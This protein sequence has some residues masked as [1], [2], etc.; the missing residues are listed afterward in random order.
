MFYLLFFNFLSVIINVMFV[1]VFLNFDIEY[2]RMKNLQEENEMLKIQLF[3]VDRI[4]VLK[5]SCI[6][7]RKYVGRGVNFV[8]LCYD[9][10]DLG[11]ESLEIQK[12]Q[13]FSRK[14]LFLNSSLFNRKLN[15]LIFNKSLI[16]FQS[17]VKIGKF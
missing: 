4:L 7:E 13:K 1:L 5:L 2:K 14:I 15:F 10:S 3:F 11:D 12:Q 9:F 8:E 17:K 6:M 16:K